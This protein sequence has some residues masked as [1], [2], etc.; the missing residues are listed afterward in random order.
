[1]L[2]EQRVLGCHARLNDMWCQLVWRHEGPHQ[3]Y[4]GSN[5][6]L[7]AEWEPTVKPR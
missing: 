1:M 5:L 7:V 4:G 2:V 6:E 3:H